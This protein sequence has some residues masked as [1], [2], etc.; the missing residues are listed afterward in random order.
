M[1]QERTINNFSIDPSFSKRSLV[2]WS[3]K[4]FESVTT[5]DSLNLNE[6]SNSINSKNDCPLGSSIGT[7]WSSEDF[8]SQ[9]QI[10]DNVCRK[11]DSTKFETSQKYK[12]EICKNFMIYKYCKFGDRCCFAHGLHELREKSNLN[13]SYKLKICKNYQQNGFCRYGQRCQYIHLK[14]NEVFNEILNT[15]I[16]KI[17]SKLNESPEDKLTNLLEGLGSLKNRLPIFLKLSKQK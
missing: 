10:I 2:N 9:N 13:N 12:T 5:R 11:E 16:S 4:S 17:C 8:Q 14:K 15:N 3:N 1:N 6:F 7:D